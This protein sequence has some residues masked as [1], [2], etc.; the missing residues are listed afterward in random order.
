MPESHIPHIV[1]ERDFDGPSLS[2]LTV[3]VVGYGSQGSA[4]ALNLRDSGVEVSVGLR[5]GSPTAE[6]AVGAG[7]RVVE[8][9]EA[10]TAD[11]VALL[12]PDEV[13]PHV[14]EH[15]MAPALRVGQTLVL[16]H[17]FALLFGGLEAPDGIDVVL[18]APMG[19]G[20][21]LRER[22]TTGSGL[23]AAF[24]VHQD[25]T[26]NARRTALEYGRA[27]GCARVGL[28]ETTVAE[29]T[30]IDLFAEQAVLAGGVTRLIEAAFDVLVEA[31]YDPAM[32]YM[33]CLYELELTVNL[34]HRY[35]ISG[36][37]DRISH[38]ALFGDLTRG[39]RIIGEETRAGMR[40]V[41][42]DVRSGVFARELED[43]VSKRGAGTEAA[44]KAARERMLYRVE[45]AIAPVAHPNREDVSEG[46]QAG[47]GT[48]RKR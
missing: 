6:S 5:D 38:T 39:D 24:A 3:G 27:I 40:R 12:V 32:A 8:V 2:G 29:E 41:L 14:F 21:I 19:P 26:G 16:A 10:A 20:A 23:P 33:E 25:A 35:G 18:V 31:G 28:F 11:V 47:G 15:E 13:L 45:D 43:D 4:Q 48:S 7:F 9:G 37:R 1:T 17:G 46:G 22:Y 44:L 30:E 34:V 36:M 42:E